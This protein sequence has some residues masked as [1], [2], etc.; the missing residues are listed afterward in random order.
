VVAYFLFNLGFLPSSISFY[1]AGAALLLFLDIFIFATFHLYYALFF[2][3]LTLGAAIA[4]IFKGRL[5]AVLSLAV[6]LLPLALAVANASE[7]TV[8]NILGLL[9]QPS[10]SV[11]LFLA[12]VCLPL[13]FLAFRCVLVFDRDLVP[14]WRRGASMSVVAAIAVA[15]A[16]S[17]YPLV[18]GGHSER[19]P[20][21]L[22]A[23][24]VSPLGTAP[25]LK[26]TGG[27]RLKGISLSLWGK[28]FP[29]GSGPSVKTYLPEAKPPI[30][31]IITI[32]TQR[33]LGRKQC[34]LTLMGSRAPNFVRARLK[35]KD[36]FELL[37]CNYPY[38]F[39]EADSSYSI[40]VPANPPAPLSLNLTLADTYSG[41]L[42]LE[43]VYA[44]PDARAT[45]NARVVSCVT[46]QFSRQEVR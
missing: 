2:V 4:I 16:L 8:R 35:V 12:F 13:L 7:L 10:A 15:A 33:F 37:D 25:F 44:E 11:S 23:E 45:G 34:T 22:Q 31:E 26:V 20:I 17:F 5:T 43:T 42:E 40:S 19:R 32:S 21:P 3:W 36:E 39:S 27:D 41:Q 6:S 18:F 9:L 24:I 29:L 14:A 28:D 1:G 30:A 38:T 46:R